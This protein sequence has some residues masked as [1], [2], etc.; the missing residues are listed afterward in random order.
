[1]AKTENASGSKRFKC[2]LVIS[3]AMVTALTMLSTAETIDISSITKA[4]GGGN[5]KRAVEKEYVSGDKDPILTHDNQIVIDPYTISFLYTNG[6]DTLGTDGI[7]IG[8]LLDTIIEH[9][10]ELS[11]QFIISMAG[12]NVGD[13]E[14]LSDPNSTRIA[15]LTPPVGGVDTGGKIQ[16]TV[17]VESPSMDTCNGSIMAEENSTLPP[18]PPGMITMEPPH[19]CGGYWFAPDPDGFL[20]ADVVDAWLARNVPPELERSAP[21]FKAFYLRLGF[22][23]FH[24]THKDG[25]PILI[26]D[27]TAILRQYPA[28]LAQLVINATE[29]LV[30]ILFSKKK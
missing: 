11:P 20:S 2:E 10:G 21:R 22:C 28:Q 6:K 17:T 18:A 13:E 19:G 1:M 29:P 25:R 30:S 26:N 15:E 14:R 4:V 8:E 3:N 16:R 12:G 27:D 23:E 5:V 24:L 9:D 7:D